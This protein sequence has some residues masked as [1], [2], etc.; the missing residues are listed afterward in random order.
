MTTYNRLNYFKQTIASLEK[1]T[2]DLSEF[3]IFDDCSSDKGKTAYLKELEG[4]YTVHYQE[5]NLG[6]MR[7]TA[8]AIEFCYL[9]Y[10]S[11]IV[12]LQD[13]VIFSRSWFVRGFQIFNSVINNNRVS[14]LC[15]FSRDKLDNEKCY[16]MKIGHPG[17]VAWI[18][19]RRWWAS[20]RNSFD[21]DD[22]GVEVFKNRP[23][24]LKVNHKIRNL[25][26]YKL[27]LRAHCKNWD[28][29]RVGK[30]LVQH[31]GDTSSLLNRNMAEF[32]SKNFVGED[33]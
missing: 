9:N 23:N 20:Y 5:K 16:I 15:L 6:T 31:I 2:A 4:K 13:D 17:G 27:S 32:R 8:R 14:Y 12:F 3:H 28:V 10:H 33:K 19:N 26:D 1:S 7:N 29:A 11:D 30:S 25:V 18:I 21:V 24:D 22:C